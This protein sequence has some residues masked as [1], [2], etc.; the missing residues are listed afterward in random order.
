[1]VEH[2]EWTA[3]RRRVKWR[4]G[5]HVSIFGPTG[6]GKSHLALALLPQRRYVVALANKTEDDTLAPLVAKGGGWTRAKKWPTSVPPRYAPRVVVWPKPKSIRTAKAEQ[7]AAFLDV[8]DGVYLGGGWCV[9]VD[10]AYY[11]SQT[12]GLGDDLKILWQQGRSARTS[13]LACSQRPAWVPLEMYSEASHVFVFRMR[14]RQATKRLSDVGSVD[15]K[16][17]TEVVAGLGDH[18]FAYVD[19]RSGTIV[20][21]RVDR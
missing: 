16:L 2:V 17:L 7:R 5:E 1:M 20:T 11:L 12:L 4:Q 19:A 6:S 10:E 18:E 3:L 13:I 8:L 21:S 9:Y 15:P 14:D